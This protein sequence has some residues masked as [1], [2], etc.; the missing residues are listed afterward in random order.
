MGLN[1]HTAMLWGKTFFPFSECR[2]TGTSGAAA[3]NLQATG[4]L[5]GPG[6]L[7]VTWPPICAAAHY[8][9]AEG[10]D[11]Q[12]RQQVAVT[13]PVGGIWVLRLMK[14]GASMGQRGM[15]AS[16]VLKQQ[17]NWLKKRWINLPS[18]LMCICCHINWQCIHKP[19]CSH[20]FGH[21]SVSF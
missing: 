9:C 18:S 13:G 1:P 11:R 19:C 20:I 5:E 7:L 17:L 4:L 16:L 6:M 15:S 14:G 2:Q 10:C 8:G 3:G 12:R 21:P